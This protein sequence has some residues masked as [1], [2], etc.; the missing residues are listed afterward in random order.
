MSTSALPQVFP[1]AIPLI[2]LAGVLVLT[3]LVIRVP[4]RRA[5]RIQPGT[6]LR[7]Q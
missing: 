5:T 6:A 2:T 3:L 4:L 7:Y 1:P